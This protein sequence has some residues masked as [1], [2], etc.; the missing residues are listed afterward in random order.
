MAYS[1]AI[2]DLTVTLGD[3]ERRFTLQAGQW[4]IAAGE[5]IG[6]TGPSGTGKTLLLE[7]L[8]MLRAPD[9][10][11]Y[12]ATPLTGTAGTRQEFHSF[13][14]D[15]NAMALCAGARAGFF[16]FVPQAGGLL[17][18]LTVTENVEITQRIAQRPDE[19]WLKALL[20]EL[21]LNQ[22]AHLR[23]GALSIGQRQRVAIARALAHRPFCVIADEP[24]AAL[25]PE[26]AQAAMGLL[27]EAARAGGTATL[28]SSH[29]YPTLEK[30]EMRRM[31]LQITSAPH[32]PNV[33]STLVA[34]DKQRATSPSDRVDV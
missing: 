34:M 14:R 29:D 5:V 4:S 2:D 28:L 9:R 33:V 8:G 16:G 17:P 21:G 6:L 15:A 25:D 27:I 23:P 13:W 12:I 10:G 31:G 32:D 7:L 1:L 18:F 11:S 26:N 3:A 30:F 19:S 20:G 22:I 24:T